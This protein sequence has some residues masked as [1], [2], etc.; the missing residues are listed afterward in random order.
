MH[1]KIVDIQYSGDYTYNIRFQDDVSGLVDFKS[2]L[3]GEAFKKLENTTY[4]KKAFIHDV[5][6]TITWPNGVDIAPETLRSK[7]TSPETNLT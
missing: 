4:F 7:L 3:W 5:T 2:F 1:D 6:G